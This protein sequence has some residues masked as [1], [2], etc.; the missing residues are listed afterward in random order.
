MSRHSRSQLRFDAR[1]KRARLN[2]VER[3]GVA[4]FPG[5]RLRPT[6]R[7]PALL[8]TGERELRAT[9]WRSLAQFDRTGSGT[10]ETQYSA[11]VKPIRV[12]LRGIAANIRRCGLR[13]RFARAMTSYV[14]LAV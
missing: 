1:L 9:C 3:A 7:N 8:V 6:G 10:E 12:A 4:S 14:K 13:K 11:R 2:I 5:K